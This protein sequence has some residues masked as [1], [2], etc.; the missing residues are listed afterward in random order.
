MRRLSLIRGCSLVFSSALMMV[1]GCR[2]SSPSVPVDSTELLSVVAISRHGIRS[3]LFS[4]AST[5]HQLFPIEEFFSRGHSGRVQAGIQIQTARTTGCRIDHFRHDNLDARANYLNSR[6][7]L[8]VGF[9]Y[10]QV[11][12]NF[13]LTTLCWVI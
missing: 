11:S 4:L 9:L 3:P 10:T 1:A 6:S 13:T 5:N 12:E 8:P 2:S 7:L